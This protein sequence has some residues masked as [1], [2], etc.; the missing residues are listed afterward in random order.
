MARDSRRL[1]TSARPK[2]SSR[3]VESAMPNDAT[4]RFAVRMN[5]APSVWEDMNAEIVARP[6]P[7]GRPPRALQIAKPCGRVGQRQL[8]CRP[9][10]RQHRLAVVEVPDLDADAVVADLR[11][12]RRVVLPDAPQAF[13]K[14]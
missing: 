9:L 5:R 12:D 8:A 13:G 6:L 2:V 1:P 14:C 11:V 10:L 3:P 7:V 4:C